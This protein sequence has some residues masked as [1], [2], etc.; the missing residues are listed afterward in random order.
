M[1]PVFI[2]AVLFDV[3]NTSYY[4]E[5]ENGALLRDVARSW[6]MILGR[7]GKYG[8]LIGKNCGNLYKVTVIECWLGGACFAGQSVDVSGLQLALV[9]RQS[10][11]PAQSKAAVPCVISDPDLRPTRYVFS[12]VTCTTFLSCFGE[13]LHVYTR[14]TKCW[15]CDLEPRA[16]SRSCGFFIRI[17]QIRFLAGCHKRRL[18]NQGSLVLLGLVFGVFILGVVGL[19]CQ[20]HS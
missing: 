7:H 8:K 20:Y 17:E 2:L 9:E 16:G 14:Y 12:L 19:F 15:S 4:V 10:E 13:I 6:K 1:F 5:A 18:I 11:M 3:S